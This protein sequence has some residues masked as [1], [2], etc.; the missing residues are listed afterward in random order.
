MRAVRLV[1]HGGPE[2][3]ELHEVAVPEPGPGD[4]LV[5]VAAAALNNTDVW[6]REGAYGRPGPPAGW[7]GPIDFPRIQGGDV[8]GRV[9]ATGSREEE[10][11]V[12]ARVVVDP[13]N[14]AD[15]DPGA[16]PVDILG[17]ERDGGYAEYVVVPASRVHRMDDSPLSDAELASLPI[18]YGTALGMAERG[19]VAAGHTVLVTG[20]SGGV[21]LAAVQI[22]A[23]RGARVVA[24]SSSGKLDAVRA[25]GA[26]AVVDRREG[27]VLADV[28]DAAPQGVDVALDVV[29]GPTLAR[30]HELLRAGGRWVVAGALDGHEVVLDV[31]ALY[32][33]NLV[34]L[35]STMHT[36]THFALLAD[37]A[38]SG[39]LRPVVARSFPLEEAA[40]A[41]VELAERRH[42]GKLVLIP[43]DEAAAPAQE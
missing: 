40:R 14:Y 36:R 24:V 4:V 27:R 23:S 22:A 16:L 42:V 8:A 11:L 13:A 10:A 28:R 25:A 35:G 1:R 29:A 26:D 34:L 38:R 20:A 2:A 33:H 12:G 21:G 17:S 30:A 9:V 18:A 19:G 31:R 37:L 43:S 39:S 6:T 15:E 3:L 7:C 32:L 41:Q 5:R